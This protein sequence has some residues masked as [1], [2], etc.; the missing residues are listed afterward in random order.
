MSEA[1]KGFIFSEEHRKH[2]SEAA[3]KVIKKPLS[4]EHKKKISNAHKRS[5]FKPP[6]MYGVKNYRWKGGITPKNK[7]IR[8]SKEYK[9]WR[10]AVFKRDNWVCIWCGIIGGKLNADHIKPFALFPELRF[11]IDN[12][13]TLCVDC[14]RKTDTFGNKK[15]K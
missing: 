11:A 5:G 14:H 4:E 3:K 9:L 10:E 7:V 1:K 15:Y 13:R 8:H 12:G 6:A 2:L